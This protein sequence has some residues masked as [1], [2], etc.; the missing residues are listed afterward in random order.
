VRSLWRS[1]YQIKQNIEFDKSDLANLHCHIVISVSRYLELFGKG[2]SGP[3]LTL[4]LLALCPQST[5]PIEI[6]TNYAEGRE[7]QY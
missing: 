3:I 1:R 2:V 5:Y 7:N 4:C 6:N